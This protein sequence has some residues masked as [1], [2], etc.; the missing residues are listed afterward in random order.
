MKEIY[1]NGF[2]LVELLVVISIITVLAT[3]VFTSLNGARK[4]AK[5]SHYVIELNQLEKALYYT[6]LDENRNTW[7]TESEIGISN[8]K[9]SDIIDIT[10]GPM[11]TFSD[12][13]TTS[14]SNFLRDG[15]FRYDNDGDETSPCEGFGSNSGGVSIMMYSMKWQD[16]LDID[17]YLDKNIDNKC[18]KI[19]YQDNP[20]AHGYT[21]LIY[22]IDLNSIN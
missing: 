19:R 17:K 7:W 6:Y 13:F 20:S 16:A 4:K 10:S 11:S 12:Y 18:G 22:E 21:Y 14:P 3:I 2:T 9:I 8:S 1:K 5:I 15:E